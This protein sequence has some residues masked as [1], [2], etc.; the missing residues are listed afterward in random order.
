MMRLYELNA[1]VEGMI[2]EKAYVEALNMDDARRKAYQIGLVHPDKG[3]N[4][5]AVKYFG[6]IQ[7][8]NMSGMTQQQSEIWYHVIYADKSGIKH[9]DVYYIYRPNCNMR[10]NPTAEL[11]RW[12]SKNMGNIHAIYDNYMENSA[13]MRVE[14]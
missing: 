7:Q 11:A 12:M 10:E 4:M 8:R 13:G 1:G 6:K 2:L 3:Y 9:N 14:W 5:L